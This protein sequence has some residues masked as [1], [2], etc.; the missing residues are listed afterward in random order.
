METILSL[1]RATA[2]AARAITAANG[3][4]PRAWSGS[5]STCQP[6]E[7]HVARRISTAR[8]GG[9]TAPR[10]FALGFGMTPFSWQ[11]TQSDRS[12]TPCSGEAATDRHAGQLARLMRHGRCSAPLAGAAMAQLSP[13]KPDRRRPRGADVTAFPPRRERR[14]LFIPQ[15]AAFA[16]PVRSP[17]TSV[18]LWRH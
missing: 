4:P 8:R 9:S 3:V 5:H 10:V 18:S 12:S 13:Q 15:V 11:S 14:C 2:G 1:S 17:L 16:V 7:L 6:E